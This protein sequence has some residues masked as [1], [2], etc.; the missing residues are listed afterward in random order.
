ML[1]L[2]CSGL[3]KQGD[4]NTRVDASRAQVEEWITEKWQP[5]FATLL[6]SACMRLPRQFE[7]CLAKD[8]LLPLLRSNPG[9]ARFF[10][11]EQGQN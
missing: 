8:Q 1:L 10:L 11:E 2:V 6:T 9:Q 4:L 3:Q 7:K 5:Q